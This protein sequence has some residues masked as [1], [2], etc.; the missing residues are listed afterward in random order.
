MDKL[1]ALRLETIFLCF[2]LILFGGGFLLEGVAAIGSPE[3]S[4]LQVLLFF[5]ILIVFVVIAT[6]IS[7]FYSSR[8]SRIERE[9]IK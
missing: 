9:L 2:L 3:A 4:S 6:L 7:N 8:K 5:I 1:T